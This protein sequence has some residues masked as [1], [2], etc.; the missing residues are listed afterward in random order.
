MMSSL[1]VTSLSQ[2]RVAWLLRSELQLHRFELRFVAK[3]AW[4]PRGDPGMRKQRL[5]EPLQ[6]VLR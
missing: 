6:I 4:L 5:C 1:Y 3:G 2:S